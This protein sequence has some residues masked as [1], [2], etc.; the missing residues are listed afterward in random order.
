M[1]K[2]LALS[3]MLLVASPSPELEAR[4]V[5]IDCDEK[6]CRVSK[7]DMEY[8]VKRD[9]TLTFLVTKFAALAKACNFKDI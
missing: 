3:V 4:E 6:V 9:H 1:F 5:N 7:E 2:A 8:I